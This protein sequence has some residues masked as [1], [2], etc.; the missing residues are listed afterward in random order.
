MSA[1]VVVSLLD[2]TLSLASV[3]GMLHGSE[4]KSLITFQYVLLIEVKILVGNIRIKQRLKNKARVH[5]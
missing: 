3:N 5:I 4:A 1:E 2:L